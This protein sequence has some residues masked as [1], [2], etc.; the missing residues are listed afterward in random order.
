MRSD[1]GLPPPDAGP[2]LARTDDP[3]AM[4]NVSRLQAG[5]GWT[6]TALFALFMTFDVVIKL[7]RLPVVEDTL[8]GIGYPPGLGFGIGVLEA[9][10]LVL[11]LAPPTAILGAIL[12]TGLF[13]GTMAS[14][15]RAGSPVASHILFGLYLGLLAWAGLWLRDLR[16][17]ALLPVRR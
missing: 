6:L 10:L 1:T 4:R 8:A 2:V 17:R 14:H 3:I 7:I 16:L 9:V 12:F 13:G 15:L 5:A 11:Y